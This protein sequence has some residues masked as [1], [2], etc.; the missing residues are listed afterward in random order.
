MKKKSFALSWGRKMFFGLGWA[1]ISVVALAYFQSMIIPQSAVGWTYFLTTFIGHYGVLLSLVYF[2]VYCPVILIFPSYYVSRIWSITLILFISLFIFLDSYLFSRY[3]FHVNSF[4][5]NFLSDHEALAGFG[6]TPLKLSIIGFVLAVL[7]VVLWIRGER[8]WRSMQA[9]F[10]NPVKNW[11]LVLIAIC[12]ITSQLMYMYGDAKGA[13][14]TTRLANLFPLHIP[15]TGKM[16]L[17][18]RGILSEQTPPVNQGYKDFYYPSENLNCGMK[19][20]KNILIIVLDKWSGSEFNKYSTPNMEHISTH[21]L[22][23]ANH[24]SGGLN[25]ND[26]YFSLLYSIPPTYAPSVLNQS[27]QPVF[28]NQLKKAKLD[29]NF[30]QSG[31][32]SP[33]TQYLPLEKEILTDYIEAS[34]AE[35]DDLAAV[36]PFLMHVFLDGGTLTDKDNQVKT[37]IDLFIQH[38]QIKNTI[39]V[40]TGAYSDEMKTPLVVIWPGKQPAT[41]TKLTSHYDVLPSIMIEDWKCKNPAS[42]FSF[43]KNVFS[44]D[45]TEKHV[46]GNY[47]TMK[48]MDTKAQ[49]ITTIDQFNGLEV[50][51]LETMSLENDKRSVPSILEV[52]QKLTS[53]YRP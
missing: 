52:L 22:S 7:F 11:Y 35:R 43:G 9:R 24:Y 19:Q 15:V 25:K 16:M 26:G 3:R 20:P 48:I 13:H 29:V 47:K 51:G 34:L 49:T 30:F 2:F 27:A 44:K 41:I 23:F 46:A 18:E 38:G 8:L 12:F 1:L 37:I 33:V 6:L 36:N 28:L 53:F 17:K 42:E 32:A 45:E 5:W 39:V 31:D 4:L 10:S 50:R 40:L 14:S 21:G